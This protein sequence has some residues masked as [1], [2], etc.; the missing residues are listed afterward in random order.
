MQKSCR[1]GM[2]GSRRSETPWQTN[3][4]FILDAEESAHGRMEGL[5]R[6]RRALQATLTRSLEDMPDC[7]PLAE[8]RI[9]PKTL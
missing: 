7:H 4:L 2:T 3:F 8:L 5:A 1:A 6:A 9:G